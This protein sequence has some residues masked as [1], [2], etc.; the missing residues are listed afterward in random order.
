VL[1]VIVASQ[2]RGNVGCVSNA[3][4]VPEHHDSATGGVKGARNADLANL[5]SI[6]SEGSDDLHYK[7]DW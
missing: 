4:A 3:D 7:V 2:D 1:D 5:T 6:D